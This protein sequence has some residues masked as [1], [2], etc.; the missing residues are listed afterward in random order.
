MIKPSFL[1]TVEDGKPSVE[2]VTLDADEA[3]KG[4]KEANK[5]VYLFLKPAFSKHK[6]APKT[7][8]KPAAKKA[9]K[10]ATK[11]AL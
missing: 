11:K 1:I 6:K 3:I 4:Y 5:E 10:K 7:A 2:I 9:A 8:P